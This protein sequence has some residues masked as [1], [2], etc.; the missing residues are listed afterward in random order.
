MNLSKIL[1]SPLLVSGRMPA[2]PEAKLTPLMNS[3]E[4]CKNGGIIGSPAYS[5]V[6]ST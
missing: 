3:A 1:T 2:P 4:G 5:A 6:S